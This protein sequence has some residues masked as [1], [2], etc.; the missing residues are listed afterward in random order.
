LSKVLSI[1]ALGGR[2]S[3]ISREQKTSKEF[4]RVSCPFSGKTDSRGKW[5][6]GME[7]QKEWQTLNHWSYSAPASLRV[8]LCA[9]ILLYEFLPP[10][11][12]IGNTVGYPGNYCRFSFCQTACFPTHSRSLLARVEQTSLCPIR[13]TAGKL[14]GRRGRAAGNYTRGYRPQAPIKI[15]YSHPCIHPAQISWDKYGI[16]RGY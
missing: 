4:A 11:G 1:V 3:R 2:F 7:P 16:K 5:P 14:I 10:P 8:G 15:Q 13:R 12:N 6:R 9:V